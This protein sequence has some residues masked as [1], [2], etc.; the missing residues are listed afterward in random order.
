MTDMADLSSA[1]HDDLDDGAATFAAARPRLFGIAYRML[2]SWTDAEDIVQEAWLR[3]QGSDRSAVGNPAA[4][5]AT[6]T[7]RLCL[8]VFQSARARRETYVGPWL[9]EAV[10]T[11][12][13][14]T[15]GAERGEA[16]EL[17]VLL[18]LEKLTPTERAAY[19]L[20]ESFDYPYAEI[21]A[22]LQLHQANARQLVSRARRHVAAERREPVAPAEHR[23]LLEVFLAAAQTGDMATLETLLAADVVSYSDGNGAA[24]VARFPVVGRARVAKFVT[25][26]RSRF[27]PGTRTDWV[28]ANGASGVLI[29]T[30]DTALALLT[31]TA[32]GQGID[33]V[34]W[35]MDPT[36]LAAF[37]RSSSRLGVGGSARA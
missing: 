12:A 24:R 33:Q 37:S 2:G 13:D 6:I 3:W 36:K 8:N 35:L 22:V 29:S 1:E 23:R 14:P 34:Q 32:S 19:I 16:L 11:S 27:W 20:R 10:D 31:V 28:E 15:V 26:F 7:T 5:L 21:A 9:P 30:R 17:A 18:L 25:A 4:F